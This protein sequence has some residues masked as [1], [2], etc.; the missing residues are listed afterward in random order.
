MKWVDPDTKE[1]V[2]TGLV[3]V[4]AQN[5]TAGGGAVDVGGGNEFGGA[6][7]DEGADD[8]EETKLDQF[9]VG[10]PFSAASTAER[11]PLDTILATLQNFPS[12]ENEVKFASFAAFK[13]DYFTPFLVTFQKLAV[14]KK[15]AKDDKDMKD[16][17]KRMA[18]VAGKW[19]KAH[20]DEIQFYTVESY[21]VDGSEVDDKFKDL[22]F[23]ANVAFVRYEGSTPYFYFIKARREGMRQWKYGLQPP[24]SSC[25]AGRVR[26]EEAVRLP[27]ES[28]VGQQSG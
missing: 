6:G 9:W 18:N 1:E 26:R 24:P 28:G 20:F 11:S 27:C 2:D 8:H 3:R 12:I 22:S 19:I 14:D 15:V 10:G 4:K 21:Y 13:K 16:K 5:Q 7:E 23:A 17:G 25:L